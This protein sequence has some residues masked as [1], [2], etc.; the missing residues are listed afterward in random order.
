MTTFALRTFPYLPKRFFKSAALV[1]EESPLTQIFLVEL[2]LLPLALIVLPLSSLDDVLLSLDSFEE[3]SHFLLPQHPLPLVG[4]LFG[5]SVETVN[6]I[7]SGSPP[8]SSIAYIR[9]R[10]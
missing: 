4:F 1:L 2:P 10:S 9:K 6:S 3:L 7:L 5:V 8:S